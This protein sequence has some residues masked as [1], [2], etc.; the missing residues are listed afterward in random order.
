M[1]MIPVRFITRTGI[2]FQKVSLERTIW[3]QVEDEPLIFT[4]SH[5]D[6]Y[7]K[8]NPILLS[9]ILIIATI[10]IGAISEIIEFQAILLFDSGRTLT[11][12]FN[13]SLNLLYSFLGTLIGSAIIV[14][15]H[16][17]NRIKELRIS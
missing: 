4:P 16:D 3:T 5:L 8:Q 17:K 13:N 12:Y 14:K 6:S 15:Y 10:G 7:S 9:L 1:A 2:K 11:T